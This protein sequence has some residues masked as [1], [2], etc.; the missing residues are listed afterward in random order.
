MRSSLGQRLTASAL[1]PSRDRLLACSVLSPN[2]ADDRPFAEGV[3]GPHLEFYPD[4]PPV[5]LADDGSEGGGGGGGGRDGDASKLRVELTGSE[6]RMPVRHLRDLEKAI[7][8]VN[9]LSR[10]VEGKAERW[11][12]SL[13][14]CGV[15]HDLAQLALVV[16]KVSLTIEDDVDLYRDYT[17][18]PKFRFQTMPVAPAKDAKG[19]RLVSSGKTKFRVYVHGSEHIFKGHGR[20]RAFHIVSGS[21]TLSR[22]TMQ[23]MGHAKAPDGGA[24]KVEGSGSKVTVKKCT[25][26]K[27]QA[28]NGGAIG[29]GKEARVLVKDLVFL[30]CKAGGYG[31]AIVNEGYLQFLDSTAFDARSGSSGGGL[32]NLPGSSAEVRESEFR[33]CYA[34]RNA[35]AIFN[36]KGALVLLEDNLFELGA[37]GE[38]LTG[39]AAAFYQEQEDEEAQKR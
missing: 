7:D 32:A 31:G 14:Y 30:S 11:G 24:L 6:M 1:A 29:V 18:N 28:R 38:G 2:A 33:Q 21:V 8:F 37:T 9:R 35:A 13:E 34:R 26:V 36:S 10:C 27:C 20:F 5:L 12:T 17:R 4:F 16:R 22:I 19:N 15:I 23:D 25:F 39:S 3:N